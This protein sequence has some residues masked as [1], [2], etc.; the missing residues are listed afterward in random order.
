MERVEIHSYSF[1]DDDFEILVL[2]D[3][4]EPIS[5]EKVIQHL[6]RH[7]CMTTNQRAAFELFDPALWEPEQKYAGGLLW[8]RLVELH[9]PVWTKA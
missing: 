8:I 5:K 9:L 1:A 3:L 7:V 4:P 6:L 2:C